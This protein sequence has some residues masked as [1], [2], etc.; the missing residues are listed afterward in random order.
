MRITN[1]MMTNNMLSNINKNKVNMTNLE[2]QYSTGKKIQRPSDDPIITVRAL[3]LRT[4]LSELSQYYEKNIPDAKSWMDVTESALTTVNEILK[5]VNTYCVQ[6]SSDTLTANDRNSIVSN[7]DQLKQQIYQEGNT[8]YAGRYVFTGYKTD[9]PLIFSEDMNNLTYKITE[10][11]SGQSIQTINK[12]SGAYELSDFDDLDFSAAPVN[13]V[14]HRIQLSYDGLSTTAPDSF[15]VVK[16]NSSVSFTEIESI[17]VTDPMAYLPDDGKAHYIP[18]TGEIILSGSVYEDLRTADKMEITYSKTGFE[19]GSLKPEHYFN[20]V[21]TDSSKPEQGEITY[22]KEKQ[23]IQYEVNYNQKLTINTEGSDAI[24]HEMG[25]HIDYIL[26]TVDDVIKTEAKIDEV[27]KRLSDTSLSQDDIDRYNQ[28]KEQLDTELELKK[29]IMQKAFS[30]G[31]TVS[32][33]EQDRVNVAV[34][35][36]GS[37]Y[38]RLELTENRLSTQKVDFE[39]LLSKNEDVDMVETVIKYN[40]AETIYNASL[41]AVS[42]VVQ[43]SLLDF[44]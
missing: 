5:Q 19:S 13:N 3:K 35:D 33:Q 16:G 9:S 7:L 29:N 1:K 6:G 18:E 20:C 11:V 2:Q 32:N 31:I 26:S 37:R 39:D 27:K 17:S 12:V 40:A 8:N 4:S 15:Q 36:L 43:K 28:L 34:A 38:V 10:D 21:M 25:R 24:S 23:Q 30:T 42:K 14:I 41:S 22:T 44:L